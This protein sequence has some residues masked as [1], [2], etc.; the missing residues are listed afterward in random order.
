MDQAGI[1]NDAGSVAWRLKTTVLTF[2][3]K[4]KACFLQTTTA[5]DRNTMSMIGI[6]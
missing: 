6:I 2:G 1:F 4:T 3:K 5:N